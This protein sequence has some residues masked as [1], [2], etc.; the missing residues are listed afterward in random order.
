MARAR[1]PFV[2]IALA[3]AVAAFLPR[4]AAAA[5]SLSVTELGFAGLFRCEKVTVVY[6]TRP[7]SGAE[8]A[9]RSAE[10][11]ASFL[12]AVH[13]MQVT[14]VADDRA[15]G[16]DLAGDL[17]VLGWSNAVLGTPRTPMPFAREV[18]RL[19][20]G[21]GPSFDGDV[22]LA[23]VHASPFNSSR[24][25]FFWSRIDAETDRFQILPFEGS[26]WIVYRRFL[27]LAQGMWTASSAWPPRREAEAEIDHRVELAEADARLGRVR[28]GAYDVV[29]DPSATSAETVEEIAS[30]RA[31]ALAAAAEALGT[32]VP[33]GFRILLRVYA[34]EAAKVRATGI[35]SAVHSF[36]RDRELHMLVPHARTPN[37]HEEIHLLAA[38]KYGPAFST[39]LYEGLAVAA[40]RQWR[41]T[42]L[43][44]AAAFLLD[45]N[46]LP[47]VADLL[48]EGRVRALDDGVSFP[49]SGLLVDWIRSKG[50]DRAVGAA[51]AVRWP[52]RA[53]I[54]AATDVPLER[55]ETEFRGWVERTASSGRTEVEAAKLLDLARERHATGDL[56]G[57]AEALRKILE[58]RPGEPQTLF[59]LA[60]VQLRTGEYDQA[61]KN[62]RAI[63]ASNLP[64]DDPLRVFAHFQLGRVLDLAGRRD[65]ALAEYRRVLELPDVHDSH[66]SAREGLAAPFT[67]DRLE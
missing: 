11:R 16:A 3:C 10:S 48:D 46:A 44:V 55:V 33:E 36:P 49:S 17:L 54:A 65:A 12:R 13:G 25:L 8:D 40:E 63:V 2:R 38:T 35:S 37:P 47:G 28:R 52:D 60:A 34:D 56:N 18:G 32:K 67:P 59:N 4:L 62:L 23:F 15:T 53:G 57:V 14:V 19:V 39:A 31:A 64:D 7:A 27:P 30:A 26:D 50:G 66:R 20:I 22:D 51:Y 29:F 9:R 21:G 42:D 6:P 45:A 5:N 58:I 24:R 41:G 43:P 1:G 61:E